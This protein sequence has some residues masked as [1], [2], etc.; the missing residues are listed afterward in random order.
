MKTGKPPNYPVAA[1][2]TGPQTGRPGCHP[3][4]RTPDQPTR[5]LAR[6][7]GF[8][9]GFVRVCLDQIYS[10]SVILVSFRPEVVPDAYISAQD[11]PLAA[12][13]HV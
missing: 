4:D 8:Q 1:R 6:L 12:L 5:S 13:D 2:L 3:V 9:T 10:G 11:A 7:T